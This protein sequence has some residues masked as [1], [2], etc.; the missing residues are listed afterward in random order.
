MKHSKYLSVFVLMLIALL[1]TGFTFAYWAGDIKAA[2]LSHKFVGDTVEIG[3]GHEVVTSL[4][5]NQMEGLNKQLVPKG[6]VKNDEVDEISRNFKVSWIDASTAGNG[7]VGTVKASDIKVLVNGKT[8][9]NND[10]FKVVINDETIN[11]NGKATMTAT[12]E[13]AREPHNKAE[14]DLVAGKDLTLEL[15]LTISE[16]K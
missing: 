6:R 3:K 12:I 2:T 11:L 4:E 13:F 1:L 16:N 7:A 14:Y 8:Y 5:V 15:T 10:L 9:N